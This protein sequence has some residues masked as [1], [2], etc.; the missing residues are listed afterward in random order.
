M[1][2]FREL[3]QLSQYSNQ[4]VPG[5]PRTYS[6]LS[7]E[8]NFALLQSVMV[9]CGAHPASCSIG[10]GGIYQGIKWPERDADHTP[11]SSDK[12]NNTWSLFTHVVSFSMAPNRNSATFTA[13][14]FDLE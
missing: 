6:I 10:T 4:T 1:L 7:N 8:R 5:H 2:A 9:S 3:G 13:H 11:P 12:V 14:H